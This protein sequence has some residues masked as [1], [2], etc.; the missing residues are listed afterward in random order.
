MKQT[1][2][3]LVCLAE[4]LCLLFTRIAFLGVGRL[5]LYPSLNHFAPAVFQDKARGFNSFCSIIYWTFFIS[6]DKL[7]LYIPLLSNYL[8]H[9]CS[10]FMCANYWKNINW[11][12]TFSPLKLCLHWKL[13]GKKEVSLE[14]R[15]LGLKNKQTNKRISNYGLDTCSHKIWHI[16][17]VYHNIFHSIGNPSTQIYHCFLHN[18]SLKFYLPAYTY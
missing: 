12:S 14:L 8:R 16:M 4:R 3:N 5:Q 11:I 1:T 15:G 2:R 9:Q 18:Y 6:W 10:R 7:R 13:C 17:N